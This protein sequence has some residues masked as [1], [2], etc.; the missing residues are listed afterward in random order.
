VPQRASTYWELTVPASGE[1]SDA[2]TNF[3]W[4]IGALGVVEEE[5]TP[6]PPRLRAFFSDASNPDALGAQVR[7]Y[8][9]GLVALGLSTPVEAR[10]TPLVDEGWADAWREHFKPIAVGRRLVVAPPWNLPPPNG[11]DVL[12]IEPGRAF[13][14]G[15]HGS[16][17]GCLEA[18]EIL[19][20][21][22]RPAAA[23]D[24]GTGSGILSIAAAKLGIPRIFAVDEDPDAV[25]ATVANAAR[26]GVSDRVR[27]ALGDAATLD[28]APAPLVIANILATVHRALA[29]RYAKLAAA[30]GALV[31]GGI[32]DAEGSDV[33]DAVTP[34]G[35]ALED[36]RSVDGWTTL[37]LRRSGRSSLSDA[38]R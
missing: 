27:C 26:N 13:G 34:E 24:L 28:T 3:L 32:L 35:F 21:R 9:E 17:I 36:L 1:S 18:I 29:G 12:V 14:T 4:E 11:R 7:D 33:A 37:V 15:H 19:I 16:T 25:A 8:I 31:L 20:E 5:I 2:L 22:E 10:L 6:E 30:G 23:I 38:H